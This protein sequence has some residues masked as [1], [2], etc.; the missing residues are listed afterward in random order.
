MNR[1]A[2]VLDT[3]DGEYCG[4]K[5]IDHKT[6]F[7]TYQEPWDNRNNHMYVS[8]RPSNETLESDKDGYRKIGYF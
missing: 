8:I 4:H 5:L 1:Y 7:F 3:D 2:I 6:R